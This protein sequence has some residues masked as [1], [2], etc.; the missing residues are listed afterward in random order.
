MKVLWRGNKQSLIRGLPSVACLLCLE[1]LVGFNRASRGTVVK[2]PPVLAQVSQTL[3]LWTETQLLIRLSIHKCNL[4]ATRACWMP[5]QNCQLHWQMGNSMASR[6]KLQ[7]VL[8]ADPQLPNIKLLV[9]KR[10]FT[11]LRSLTEM[12]VLCS[13]Q[14]L[15]QRH[16]R[17]VFLRGSICQVELEVLE[18]WLWLWLSASNQPTINSWLT[19]LTGEADT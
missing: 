16:W 2:R 12:E 18:P 13:T 3:A 19:M 8:I 7:I 11:I 9:S 6:L 17:V 5:S 10:V 1:L 14:L 15:L 4:W